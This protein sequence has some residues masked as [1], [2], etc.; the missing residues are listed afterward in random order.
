[1]NPRVTLVLAAVLAVLIGVYYWTGSV[2]EKRKKAEEEK[3]RVVRIEGAKVVAIDL[4]RPKPAD[5]APKAISLR[6][7]NGTWRVTKP[8]ALR[9]DE[10][11]VQDLLE[12]LGEIKRSRVIDESA[13]DLSAFGLKPAKV[14]VR[15]RLEGDGAGAL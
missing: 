13:D 3:A 12:S 2:G 7:Q 15:Y 1:M 6:K 5:S 10:D 14:T 8:L 9:A 4:E 11:T